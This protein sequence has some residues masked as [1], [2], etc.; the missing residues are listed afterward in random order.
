ML[1]R[2]LRDSAEVGA[3]FDLRYR[4]FVLEQGVAPVLEID[5]RDFAPRNRTI[6]IGLFINNRLV[7]GARLLIDSPTHI[8]I[9]R[10]VVEPEQRGRG[11]GHAIM[12][13]LESIAQDALGNPPKITLELDAQTRALGFYQSLGYTAFGSEFDDAGIPHRSMVK[14]IGVTYRPHSV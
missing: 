7:A 8:H 11:L 5:A 9:G 1:V 13:G 4:V 3:Y 6:P 2:T 14:T 12:R 10:V